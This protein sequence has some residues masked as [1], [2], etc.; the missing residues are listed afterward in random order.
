VVSTMIAV[1]DLKPSV[2]VVGYAPMA[3]NMVSGSA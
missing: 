2:S 1:A 3:E